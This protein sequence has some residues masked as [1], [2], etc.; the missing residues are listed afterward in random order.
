MQKINLVQKIITSIIYAAYGAI[1]VYLMTLLYAAANLGIEL[2]P[3]PVILISLTIIICVTTIIGIWKNNRILI[4]IGL[5]LA[6]LK[7]LDTVSAVVNRVFFDQQ[8]N[9]WIP[10]IT[11]LLFLYAFF[12]LLKSIR[13]NKLA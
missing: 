8:L 11:G 4:I 6:S 13:G 3:L 7:L 10:I 12:A 9:L 1:N 2:T 5:A